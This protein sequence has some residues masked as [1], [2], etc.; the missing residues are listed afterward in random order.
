MRLLLAAAQGRRVEERD[1]GAQMDRRHA[2]FGAGHDREHT[3]AVF[4]R[5]PHAARQVVG[6]QRQSRPGAAWRVIAVCRQSM[7]FTPGG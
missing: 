5:A 1:L 4:G 6:L 2:I 7:T 3:L